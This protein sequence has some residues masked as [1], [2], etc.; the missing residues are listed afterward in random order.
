ML[1]RLVVVV[2]EGT[3]SKEDGNDCSLSGGGITVTGLLITS[4]GSV[5]DDGDTSMLSGSALSVSDTVTFLPAILCS[6]AT[7]LASTMS[8]VTTHL[9]MSPCSTVTPLTKDLRCVMADPSVHCLIIGPTSS[10]RAVSL[11][12]T[13][14]SRLVNWSVKQCRE[15]DVDSA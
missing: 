10:V 2:M 13:T 11:S 3:V 7:L 1:G 8:E 15:R 12:W 14:L 4:S 5:T 6:L 9:S